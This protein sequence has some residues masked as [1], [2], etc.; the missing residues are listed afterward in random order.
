VRRFAL[1]LID[2]GLAAELAFIVVLVDCWLPFWLSALGPPKRWF[3]RDTVMGDDREG[4]LS[5]R[6][7]FSGLLLDRLLDDWWLVDDAVVELR[8]IRGSVSWA[9]PLPALA[10]VVSPP[11]LQPDFSLDPKEEFLIWC[12]PWWYKEGGVSLLNTQREAI[13]KNVDFGLQR[14][15]KKASNFLFRDIFIIIFCRRFMHVSREAL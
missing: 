8:R 14:F 15:L 13:F 2:A 11:I 3:N 1:E 6:L 10:V 12:P 5:R 4:R 7:E 9:P